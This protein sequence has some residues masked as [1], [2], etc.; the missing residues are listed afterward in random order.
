[1]SENT[2]ARNRR[3]AIGFGSLACITLISFV[4]AFV[5]NAEAKRQAKLAVENQQI[6]IACKAEND[7]KIKLLEDQKRQ[8]EITTDNLRLALMDAQQQKDQAQKKLK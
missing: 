7:E 8:L 3:M 6:A 4:Y 2:I 5:Q 1:M